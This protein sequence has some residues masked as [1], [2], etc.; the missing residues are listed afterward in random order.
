MVLH[1]LSNA[2]RIIN[3]LLYQAAYGFRR[4]W[5]GIAH[6][7]R[8]PDLFGELG[9]PAA[10]QIRRRKLAAKIRECRQYSDRIHAMRV[11]LA[12]RDI[13]RTD[14]QNHQLTRLARSR[15]SVDQ[16]Q[17][18]VSLKQVVGQVHTAYSIVDELGLDRERLRFSG[19][20]ADDLRSE[21]V[22]AEKDVSDPCDENGWLLVGSLVAIH[23]RRIST[24]RLA[25]GMDRTPTNTPTANANA[26]KMT[27][28]IP[29]PFICSHLPSLQRINWDNFI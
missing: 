11:E 5:H 14:L 15:T 4:R 23:I 28:A 6:G 1:P 12:A 26:A 7:R 10:H 29:M 8:Q 19:K 2:V 17:R 16:H 20:V 24:Y 3:Q 13:T 9:R 22:V 18:V 25:S 21:P 27:A